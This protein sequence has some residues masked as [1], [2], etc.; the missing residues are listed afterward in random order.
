MGETLSFMLP[1]LDFALP[2]AVTGLESPVGAYL[3]E[4]MQYTF[5]N[6]N[7]QPGFDNL[8]AQVGIDRIMF[9]TD[10]PFGSMVEARTFLSA[11]PLSED[12]RDH[13]A[14]RNAERLLRL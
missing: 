3:R 8:R 10:Y 1:R 2:V 11:L 4:N 13:I 7:Y 14:H 6:F 12:E 5:A 9:S